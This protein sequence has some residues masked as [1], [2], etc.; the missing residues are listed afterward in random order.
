MEFGSYGAF[1]DEVAD[2]APTKYM[3]LFRFGK[4]LKVYGGSFY[5]ADTDEYFTVKMAEEINRDCHVSIPTKDFRVP[6]EFD[7]KLGIR[8]VLEYLAAGGTR[9]LYVGCM[10]GRG[11]TGLFMACL[12][13]AWGKGNPIQHVR[14]TYLASAVETKQQEEYVRQLKI[15]PAMR[16]LVWRAKLAGWSL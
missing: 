4:D 2:R 5:A 3:S 11:R 12:A 14:K 16:L 1:G 15:T 6:N 8:Q 9:D 7:L 13:K 10:G